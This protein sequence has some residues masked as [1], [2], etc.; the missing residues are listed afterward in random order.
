MEQHNFLA[1]QLGSELVAYDLKTVTYK[2]V[3]KKASEV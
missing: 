1:Y 2:R 3:T